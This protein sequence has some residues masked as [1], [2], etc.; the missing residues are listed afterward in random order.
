MN[1]TYIVGTGWWCTSNDTR[2]ARFLNGDDYIRSKQF[3]DLWA[4]SIVA[5]SN[6][7]EVV[8]IDSNSPI[9]A[10]WN[11]DKLPYN[12]I[13]LSNNLGHATSLTSGKFC[14]WTA[15]VLLSMEYASFSS[16]DFYVYIEQD[17][18]IYGKG[19]IEKCIEG[20]GDDTDYF[21][22]A[23]DNNF[24][25]LQ[26]SFFIVRKTAI[27]RFCSNLRRINYNDAQISPEVKF[28]IASSRFFSLLPKMLF[29]Q[30]RS[31]I[32]K[33]WRRFVVLF[34][35]LISSAKYLP[36]GY[37]RTRPINFS[38]DHFYFQ[39]GSDEELKQFSDLMTQ[40]H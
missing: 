11:G 22:G 16:C 30:N 9:K 27:D 4:E 33:A 28:A 37:G 14:G 24:S 25:P 8:V 2:E 12:V 1:K 31:L 29:K 6:P 40:K 21:F 26:Q 5:F 17:V 20:M 13:T 32:G 10:N 39:H 15:S 34:S 36:I 7:E 38:D 3:H 35:K 19:I 18:L 23:T